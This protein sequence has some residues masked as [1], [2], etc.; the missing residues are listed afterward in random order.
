MKNMIYAALCGC[1][2]AGCASTNWAEIDAG[3]KP[4]YEAAK[5]R[6]I[7]FLKE[8]LFDP[9]SAR[10]RRWTPLF[11]AYKPAAGYMNLG[12]SWALCVEMNAK[13]RLGGYVGYRQYAL[14]FGGDQITRSG[15]SASTCEDG[16]ANPARTSE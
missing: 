9:E 11:K 7:F 8:P 12:P 15:T 13:N 1:L 3:P 4:E 16:P 10:F 6:A 5:E 2:L 14:F